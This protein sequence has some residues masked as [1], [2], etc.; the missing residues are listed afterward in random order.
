MEMLAEDDSCTDST[1]HPTHVTQN[2]SHKIYF[3]NMQTHEGNGLRNSISN[4]GLTSFTKR[5]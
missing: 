3:T 1:S 5:S 4:C 2:K